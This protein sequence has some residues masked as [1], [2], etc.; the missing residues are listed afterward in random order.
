MGV[1]CAARRELAPFD[2]GFAHGG[3]PTL[4]LGRRQTPSGQCRNS[5]LQHAS[6][7]PFSFW[8]CWSASAQRLRRCFFWSS[9]FAYRVGSVG[10]GKKRRLKHIFRS[11]GPLL[12]CEICCEGIATEC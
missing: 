4:R 3:L 9:P 6:R 2:L 7:I 10:G 12:L 5:L 1:Q 11:A 8:R